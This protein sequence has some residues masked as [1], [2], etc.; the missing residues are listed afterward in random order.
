MKIKA[1][2]TKTAKIWL[3][4][5]GIIHSI[6]LPGSQTSLE[7]A[8]KAIHIAETYGDKKRP[9]YVDISK[10]KSVSREARTY[11][12]SEEAVKRINVCAMKV[13]PPISKVI[14]NFFLGIN[15]P[16]Y[17]IKQFTSEDKAIRWLQNH[18]E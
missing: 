10:I 4:E 15:K 1:I 3:G 11:F 18:V 14:G 17:P 7:D 16:P 9:L 8:K 6:N 13:D 5:D 12:T 2:E